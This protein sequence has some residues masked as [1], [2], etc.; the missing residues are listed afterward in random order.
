MSVNKGQNAF[1]ENQNIIEVQQLV[2]GYET[3]NKAGILQD[4]IKPKVI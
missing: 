3:L 2:S 4:C 1:A